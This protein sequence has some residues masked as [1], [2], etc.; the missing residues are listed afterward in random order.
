MQSRTATITQFVSC[1]LIEQ[2]KG[3]ELEEAVRAS[4]DHLRSALP[5]SM[6]SL[7]SRHG[8]AVAS[9][10]ARQLGELL[11]VSG[12]PRGDYST[13]LSA[14]SALQNDITET[15]GLIATYREQVDGTRKSI[16]H[17]PSLLTI[18]GA[19]SLKGDFSPHGFNWRRITHGQTS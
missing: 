5:Q 14:I 13:F 19:Y 1:C 6:E 12:K 17:S 16:M 10:V 8:D 18:I 7:G 9:A 11:T 4:A 2:G 15:R 3:H